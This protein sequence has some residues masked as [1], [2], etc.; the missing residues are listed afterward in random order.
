MASDVRIQQAEEDPTTGSTTLLEILNDLRSVGY[1]TQLIAQEGG[2]VRCGSCSETSAASDIEPHGYRRTEGASD[3]ADMNLVIWSACPSCGAGATLI[4]GYGPNA[5]AADES[6][7]DEFSLD[8][9]ATP[10]ATPHENE[11]QA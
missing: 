10:G 7:L 8:A 4:L 9:T 1:A 5:S 11:S 6:V 2:S 3:A